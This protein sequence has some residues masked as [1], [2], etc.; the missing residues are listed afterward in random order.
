MSLADEEWQ[1]KRVQED[2]RLL[3]TW[4]RNLDKQ[5]RSVRLP[6]CHRTVRLV[7]GE[8]AWPAQYFIGGTMFRDGEV[9]QRLAVLC[10]SYVFSFSSA[11]DSETDIHRTSAPYPH[12]TCVGIP[13]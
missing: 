12:L 3:M 6:G 10:T 13:V 5:R 7:P 8:R 11:S 4:A 2:Q 9:Q 1:G